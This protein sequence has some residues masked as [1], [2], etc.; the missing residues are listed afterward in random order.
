MYNFTLSIYQFTK[1]HFYSFVRLFSDQDSRR[2]LSQAKMSIPGSCSYCI[3]RKSRTWKQVLSLEKE[4]VDLFSRASTT[5]SEF[6]LLYQGTLRDDVRLLVDIVIMLMISWVKHIL[7]MVL[8][9]T[10]WMI[11]GL[12]WPPCQ[13]Q[14]DFA[15]P[16]SQSLSAV[17]CHVV[18]AITN[19]L[20][21]WLLHWS[22][23]YSWRRHCE[24]W[25]YITAHLLLMVSS[26]ARSLRLDCPVTSNTHTYLNLCQ[27]TCIP[28]N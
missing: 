18:T 11:E 3:Y 1:A 9:E 27:S 17:L 7:H 4:L 14:S 10:L 23:V 19:L 16:V 2:N 22:R 12:S 15:C 26:F 21:N 24:H 28:C 13:S 5:S 25:L 20:C 6:I 8:H